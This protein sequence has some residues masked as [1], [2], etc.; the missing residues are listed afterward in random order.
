LKVLSFIITCILFSSGVSIAQKKD[1]GPLY[2]REISMT[3]DNDIFFFIDYYYTA[4]Q[5]IQYRR[6]ADPQGWLSR[7][8]ARQDSDSSKTIL[9]Y[10]VG[11][12][13]FT[14]KNI[15]FADTKTMDRPYAG[16]TSGSV[17]IASF[18]RPG[19]G[20]TYDIEVGLVGRISGMGQFQRWVHRETAFE[21][22]HGWNSEIRDEVVVNLYYN[23]YMEKLINP[24]FDLVTQSTLQA[25][26][27]GNRISQHAS[28]RTGRFNRINNSVFSQTRL[29]WDTREQGKKRRR[30]FFLFVGV[31][32]D[33]VLSNIFIE[34]SLFP[35]HRSDF[36]VPLQPL[37][38]QGNL[39]FMFSSHAFS[40]TSTY[41]YL[42]REAKH[43]QSHDYA[44]LSMAVRF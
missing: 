27:G 1:R 4:G 32:A 11:C 22:P 36:T 16:W 25:G 34:G 35:G 10:H 44:S 38:I 15:D 5:D 24:K 20:N 21:V 31:A 17:G 3:V 9:N 28:L 29:N 39:G 7:L 6:L 19:V 26:T 13:I 40:W 2:S 12:K 41:Y 42:T 14:P 43:G 18:N 37:V 8:F 33:Y 30:E 23:R